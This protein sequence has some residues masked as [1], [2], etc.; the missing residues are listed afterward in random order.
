MSNDESAKLD[1][2]KQIQF[3]PFDE[4]IK[5]IFADW[6]EEREDYVRAALLRANGRR[7]H[8]MIPL[9]GVDEHAAGCLGG[10]RF[11]PATFDKRFANDIA[12]KACE[13]P[14]ALTPKQY[15]W[16]WCLLHRYRRS[17]RVASIKAEAAQRYDSYCHMLDVARLKPHERRA[18][19]EKYKEVF[20]F[21]DSLF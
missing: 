13:K 6:L 17:V 8:G 19:P 4:T 21:A 5:S 15:C 2:I 16:M 20:V 3:D 1:F 7:K 12:A 18:T 14:P 10:C 9:I 11:A